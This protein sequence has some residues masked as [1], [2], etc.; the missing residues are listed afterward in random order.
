MLSIVAKV[1]FLRHFMSGYY[2]E[3][4]RVLMTIPSFLFMMGFV[5]HKIA[6][7]QSNLATRSHRI[8]IFV[9]S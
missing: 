2:P 4:S 1:K 7:M 9:N 5:R 3:S 6:F 8:V